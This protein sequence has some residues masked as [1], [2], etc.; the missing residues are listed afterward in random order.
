MCWFLA[1]QWHES[2]ISIPISPSPTGPPPPHAIL[3]DHRRALWAPCVILNFPLSVCV[4]HGS[5]YLS[6]LLSQCIPLLLPPFVSTCPFSTSSSLF[7]SYKYVHLY[8]FSRLHMYVLISDTY[9]SL[10]DILHS[11]WRT[12]G[13]STSLPMIPIHFF[14]W[15]S[16]IPLY[17]CVTTSLSIHLLMSI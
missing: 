7:L 10:S 6:M 2:A 12:L 17:I 16:N 14:L 8:C 5:V 11:V 13:P 9:F 1:I 3:L 15:L 4:T